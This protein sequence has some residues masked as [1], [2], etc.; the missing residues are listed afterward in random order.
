MIF[1]G[2]TVRSN[3][4][5]AFFTGDKLPPA[6]D[7]AAIGR[8]AIVAPPASAIVITDI[9]SAVAQPVHQHLVL[10]AVDLDHRA[11]DE[12]GEI[13][14]KIGDEVGDF[15]AFGDTAEGDA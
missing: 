1:S 9:R 2:R 5:A 13:G 4:K 11:V 3:V 15:V 6:V 12:K 8:V 14:G 7:V 10:T